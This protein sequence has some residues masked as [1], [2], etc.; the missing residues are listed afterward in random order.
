MPDDTYLPALW[1]KVLIE[2][3]GVWIGEHNVD[4]IVDDAVSVRP[5]FNPDD[6][7]RR[8][9][10]LHDFAE[11]QSAMRRRMSAPRTVQI[12]T[13]AGGRVFNILSEGRGVR[14]PRILGVMMGSLADHVTNGLTYYSDYLSAISDQTAAVEQDGSGWVWRLHPYPLLDSAI[15]G[16]FEVGLVQQMTA[17]TTDGDPLEVTVER[18]RGTALELFIH[19]PT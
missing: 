16:A 1:G 8:T 2:T 18:Q 7:L 15:R 13:V 14:M 10:P 3:L 4:A 5:A 9:L 11:L 6:P 17:H 12:L 19:R